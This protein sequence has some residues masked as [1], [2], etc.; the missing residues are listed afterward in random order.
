[1]AAAREGDLA[2][3]GDL[4]R[5]GRTRES[6]ELAGKEDLDPWLF[7]GND[8]KQEGTEERERRLRVAVFSISIAAK[9]FTPDFKL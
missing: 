3:S 7:C 4:R 2:I 5:L 8:G 9:G 1:M 6:L